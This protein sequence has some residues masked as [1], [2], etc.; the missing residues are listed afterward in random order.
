[1][2]NSTAK[3][4]KSICSAYNYGHKLYDE[5]IRRKEEKMHLIMKAKSEKDK[6]EQDELSFHPKINDKSIRMK[7]KGNEK[8]ED[9]LI[10]YGKAVKNKRDAQ[11]VE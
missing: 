7:R 8:A 9:L 5:G 2:L 11:R 6:Q 1:M 4:Q 10:N 3:S